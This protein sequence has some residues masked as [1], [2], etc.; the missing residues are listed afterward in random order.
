[1]STTAE[2]RSPG[3]VPCASYGTPHPGQLTCPDPAAAGTKTRPAPIATTF[4]GRSNL[5]HP[6][7]VHPPARRVGEWDPMRDA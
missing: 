1:M 7:A 2:G 3:Q 6:V 4:S 5:V